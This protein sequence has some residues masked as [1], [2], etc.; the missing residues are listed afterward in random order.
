MTQAQRLLNDPKSHPTVAFFFDNLLPISILTGLTVTASF[1][2]VVAQHR[3]R[4]AA[5][6]Q[7]VLEHEIFENTTQVAPP[8]APGSWPAMLTAPY[9]FVN[10]ALFNYYGASTFASGTTVTG[11]TLTK[12]NLNTSQRLGLLTLRRH[13]GGLDDHQPHQPGAARR[14]HRQQ[15][16]VP[17]HRAAD[18]VHADAARPVHRQDRARALH[19]AHRAQPSAP[20]A[21]STWTRWGFPLEN[22]DAVGLYR[23]TEHWT[24]PATT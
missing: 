20:V 14:L 16:D 24:D 7:R 13:G 11:T 4:D 8:H 9:T 6:V 18:R 15:A 3:R 23:T 17:E 5:E 10:Q 19:Q 12:V 2:D 1:P 22:Y 21:T